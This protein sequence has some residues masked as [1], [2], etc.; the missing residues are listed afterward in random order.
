MKRHFA[1]NLDYPRHAVE[2]VCSP[3]HVG[4]RFS[5]KRNPDDRLVSGPVYSGVNENARVTYA[6][7]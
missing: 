7:K 2:A 4:R 5:R 1:P 6:Q 3:F